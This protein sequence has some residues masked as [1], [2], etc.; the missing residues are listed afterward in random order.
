M[1]EVCLTQESRRVVGASAVEQAAVVGKEGLEERQDCSEVLLVDLF[2]NDVT[3]SELHSHVEMLLQLLH[4][5][6][7]DFMASLDHS[8][9]SLGKK[10]IDYGRRLTFD[11]EI[12]LLILQLLFIRF[13]KLVDDD[14]QL[15]DSVAHLT[16]L[17]VE[18]IEVWNLLIL[19]LVA[20]FSAQLLQL[21]EGG[22]HLLPSLTER[23]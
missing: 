22:S 1:I 9:V 16:T 5:L 20:K 3:R 11:F 19:R 21:L 4:K 14:G 15:F 18:H 8:A 2:L 17:F 13:A 23:R 6:R 7:V 12:S 10:V